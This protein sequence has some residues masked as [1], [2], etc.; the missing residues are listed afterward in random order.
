[1]SANAYAAAAR[2]S[3]TA[4]PPGLYWLVLNHAPREFP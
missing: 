1:M 3:G 4:C 2:L